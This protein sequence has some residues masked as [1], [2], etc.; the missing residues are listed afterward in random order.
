MIWEF[1][2]DNRSSLRD[3]DGDF[4]DWIE[5][6]NPTLSPIE[7]EGWVLTNDP[8]DLDASIGEGDDQPLWKLPEKTLQPDEYLVVF[9]S[10]KDRTDPDG[11]LHTDF[12]LSAN[13]DYLALFRV[14]DD[15]ITI[16]TEFSPQ[17]P[18]Q[19]A[20]QTFGMARTRDVVPLVDEG[21][22]ASAFVPN[23]GSLGLSWTDVDF[24]DSSWF[25]GTTAIGFEQVA[26]A[27][28]IRD[29]FDADLGP[30]WSIDIPP[31]GTSAVSTEA[32]KLKMNLPPEQDS[33]G[34][35]G[36]APLLLREAPQQNSDYEM[37]TRID[38]TSGNG[39]GGIVVV[40]GA[41]GEPAFSVQLDRAS[42]FISQVK[43]ISGDKT[44]DSLVLFNTSNVFLRMVRDTFGDSW[45][46]YSK[47]SNADHWHELV[48]VTEGTGNVPQIDSPQIGLIGRSGSGD[49][50]LEFDFF[51]LVVADEKAV[52][53]P[54]TGLNVEGHMFGRNA[55]V[56][57]RAPFTVPGEPARLDELDLTI[58]Y[59]DGFI[60][61]VN[62]AEVARR[63]A[64]VVSQWNSQA[65]GAHGARAGDIPI[66]VINLDAHIGLLQ[67]GEN[68]LAIHGLNVLANDRDLFLAPT[69]SAAEIL[70]TTAQPFIVPTPG[71]EN[72]LPAAPQ[73]VFSA[74][75]GTFV[76]A[77]NVELSI[78]DVSPPF[79]IR[80]TLDGTVPTETS[81]LY[82]QPLTFTQ[83]TWLRAR[84]FSSDFKRAFDPS[85]TAG[86]SYIEVHPDLADFDS[87]LPVVVLDTMGQSFPQTSSPAL[88]PTLVAVFDKDPV[89]DRAR[90]VDGNLDYSGLA[91]TRRYGADTGGNPKPEL[92]L[93]TWGNVAEHLDV[94]LL[95]LPR[96]SD[97]ILIGPFTFDRTLIHEPFMHDLSNDIG[98]Y[99]ART[100]MVEVYANTSVGAIGADANDYQG[101]YVLV[102]RLQQGPGRIDV[103][104]AHV[105]ATYDPTSSVF[106]QPDPAVTGGYVWRID[107]SLPGEPMFTAGGY[108]INWV[109][110]RNAS[111]PTGEYQQV[112]PDQQ[113]YVTD[114]F[115]E[116]WEVLRGPN[117]Y[118]PVDGYAKYI[119]VGSWIDYHLLNVIA[120]N[121]DAQR[122]SAYLHKDI[123]GKIVFG[124]IW[125]F[126]RAM[127]SIDGRDDD[128]LAWRGQLGDL[129]T[130]FF[131]ASG[132]GMGG[133]WWRQLFQDPNFF[134]EYVDRYWQLRRG[135][136]PLS[137]AAISAR[138][139]KWAAQV[140]EAA[141][142]NFA[143]WQQVSPRRTS[144]CI[145]A[146][147]STWQ[148]E[149]ENMRQW[150]LAR[151]QF[152]DETFAPNPEFLVNGEQVEDLPVGIEVS[153]GAQFELLAPGGT[154][155]I[156]YTTDGTD[157]RGSDGLPGPTAVPFAPPEGAELVGE[158]TVGS[159]LIPNGDPAEDGWQ[160]PDYDDSSWSPA[161][162]SVG[163]DNDPEGV[164]ELGQSGFLVRAIELVSPTAT[165][166]SMATDIFEG[167]L[168]FTADSDEERIDPYINHTADPDGSFSA[169]S[170]LSPPGIS[171]GVRKYVLRG[172]AAVT[173]PVGTWTVA[174]G[175]NEGMRLTIPGVQFTNI[176]NTNT[177]G[178]DTV[179]DDQLVFS[180]FSRHSESRGT[181][182]VTGGPLETTILLDMFE[183]LG[184]D[185]L[186]LSIAQG[187]ANAFN[188]T[189]FT[190]L[191][192][193]THGWS[194]RAARIAAN[195]VD[196]TPVI[197]TDLSAEMLGASSSA[198]VR[199]PFVV[200]DAGDVLD[201]K[202]DVSSDDGFAAYLN[203]TAV[204]SVNAPASLAFD[205]VAIDSTLDEEALTTQEFDLDG[206][207]D[208]L[209]DGD[210][211]L[212]IH[213]LNV[214]AD[215]TDL[216]LT[217]RL[218]TSIKGEPV[219][220]HENTR[221]I[222][223]NLDT[224]DRGPEAEIVNTAWSAPVVHDL[225]TGPPGDF[226]RDGTV[227]ADDIDA[228]FAAINSGNTELRFDL[229]SNGGV[230]HD[231]VR[232][233]VE[234]ILG[235]SMGD[236]NLDGEVDGVDLNRLGL[237]WRRDDGVGWSDGDFNGDGNIDAADLNVLELSWTEIAS[238]SM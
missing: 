162:T 109:Y 5:I 110:P 172:T 118:D 95:G 83:T 25:Q 48:T 20:D 128:P 143:R 195:R 23:D 65:S 201:L 236:A 237:N 174:V 29:D 229:D 36:L 191:E 114:Y 111:N 132:D 1:Q 211:V 238:T 50:A 223:R 163:F 92:T 54:L 225:V 139:D 206:F 135:D 10:G 210:N 79:E 147:D 204:A 138:I 136:G 121:V 38:I 202:L 159:F 194:V 46:T 137:D 70:D 62:G 9:A 173:I 171:T 156:Y 148:G 49:M 115:D 112:T 180:V 98:R 222:A 125:D 61:Y 127:E 197:R 140:E 16:G 52:Y 103:A 93:Q 73:P 78:P 169:P 183:F 209:Q 175:S 155:K 142:R 233:L 30:E 59:D 100:V 101:V 182:T 53:E 179:G 150:L 215:D 12:D 4:S 2:A 232:F 108:M 22:A 31:G 107:R 45:T 131:G 212:A 205:S 230:D 96:A 167:A 168:A 39:A 113:A 200:E 119:D 188:T 94:E 81:S 226:D 34:D 220:I 193:G 85:N 133:R 213:A 11:E 13:G 24:D 214:A 33:Y 218:S 8:R 56:Y 184:N 189:D 55:S 90:I 124:P 199:Y 146:C 32:G 144:Q 152:M 198:Y 120:M 63:N 122:L 37:L 178:L 28:T 88:A 19:V 207:V 47:R 185:S 43:T 181:F 17:F 57:T 74:S 66:E 165:K 153:P 6:Y 7:L 89:T 192:D 157:P 129:G 164:T 99:A 161:T 84:T 44:V 170:N 3:E 221:I 82:T 18:P 76:G 123:N 60:A 72:A 228:L 177:S 75:G 134:Q 224:S 116:F 64:P 141:D 106:D 235:T 21:A 160:V 26:P 91:G 104:H 68:V 41:T 67:T 217:T 216:L 145:F 166:I 158:E 77:I 27:F 231:D 219:S 186:E 149:I 151:L 35:R 97:W 51:E 154:G 14:D 69:L 208:L 102:E 15:Q 42:S 105:N 40:D 87:N 71:E 190:I 196:Y 80:Y 203:G 86:E 126:D 117:A 234:N 130:D 187:A 58:S 176:T 227:D